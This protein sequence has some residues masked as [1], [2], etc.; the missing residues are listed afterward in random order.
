MVTDNQNEPMN[1]DTDITLEPEKVRHLAWYLVDDRNRWFPP[2][3]T[4]EECIEGL[5]EETYNGDMPESKK[6]REYGYHAGAFASA[7]DMIDFLG[8]LLGVTDRDESTE[9]VERL[10]KEHIEESDLDL[11]P[12]ETKEGL[13]EGGD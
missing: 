3:E 4:A 6:D 12:L 5:E 1:D 10:A 7:V 11:P 8:G 2:D 13:L 9:L